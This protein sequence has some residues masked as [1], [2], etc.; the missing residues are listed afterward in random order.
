MSVAQEHAAMKAAIEWFLAE[1]AR[2]AKRNSTT[3]PEPD[4]FGVREVRLERS[5]VEG[6][7]RDALQGIP[8]RLNRNEV[9]RVGLDE[10]GAP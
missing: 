10:G 2:A 8:L 5:L 4:G 6:V 1:T 3:W 9:A 7:F